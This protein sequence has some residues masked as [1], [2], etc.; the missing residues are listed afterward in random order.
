MRTTGERVKSPEWWDYGC[1][2]E[3][4]LIHVGRIRKCMLMFNPLQNELAIFG[5]PVN[6]LVVAIW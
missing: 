4:M 1:L 5:L 6:H 3:G 2:P